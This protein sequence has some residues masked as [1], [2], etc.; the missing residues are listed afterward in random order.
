MNSIVEIENAEIVSNDTVIKNCKIRGTMPRINNRLFLVVGKPILI[1]ISDAQEL[2]LLT[3]L[4]NINMFG[5]PYWDKYNETINF[6][7]NILDYML[8][9]HIK[10]NIEQYTIDNKINNI[11]S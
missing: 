9:E 7:P 4:T 8:I 1:Y 6:N 2:Q 10:D 3:F 11:I 5:K